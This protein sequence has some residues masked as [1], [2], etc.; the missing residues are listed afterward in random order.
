MVA[1]AAA[2]GDVVTASNF[3]VGM[4]VVR[5]ALYVRFCRRFAQRSISAGAWSRLGMG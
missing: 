2:V 4:I 1:G 5:S 3:K